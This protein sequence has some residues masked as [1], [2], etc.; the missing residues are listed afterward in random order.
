M[1][2]AQ[3]SSLLPET[4]YFRYLAEALQKAG[5]EV[6]IY[7]DKDPKNLS[8]GLKNVYL[9]WDKS[10]KYWW[11]IIRRARLDKPDLVHLQHEVNMFGG[12]KEA[13]FFPLLVFLLRLFGFRLVTTVHA[14][15]EKEK[16]DSEFLEINKFPKLGFLVSPVRFFFT[17]VYKFSG[18]FSQKVIVHSEGL[19]RILATD[20]KVKSDKIVVIPHGVPDEINI[21]K[22]DPLDSSWW[23][24]VKDQRFMLYFGYLHRRKGLEQVIEGFTIKDLRFKNGENLLRNLGIKLVIAG[25]TLQTDYEESLRKLVR[26]LDLEDEVIFCGFVSGEELSWLLSRCEFVVAPATYSISASGPLAQVIAHEKPVILTKIGVFAE[27]LEDGVSGIY[28]QPQNPAGWP[29]NISQSESARGWAEAMK[30][31][32]ED[33]Q[34]REKL[35]A[36]IKKVHEER[37]W[38]K[39]AKQHIGVYHGAFGL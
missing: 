36:G 20:Y 33:R 37:G 11:Q 2:I 6:L 23:P 22:K 5:E 29:R 26:D 39:I 8:T 32:L 4:N 25:G 7:A 13:I 9:V 10:P 24:K 12:P 19:K 16:I 28:V 21:P 14:V 38:S 34:L 31:L 1:K 15:V 35:V 18:K 3:V 17:L 27:E 30:L